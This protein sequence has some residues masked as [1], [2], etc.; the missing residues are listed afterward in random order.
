VADGFAGGWPA[1]ASLALPDG[2]EERVPVA[3]SWVAGVMTV[4][5]A[6]T[7]AGPKDA[8]GAGRAWPSPRSWDMAARLLAAG[9][10]A[11]ADELVSSALVRGCVGAGAGA[12]FATWLAE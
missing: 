2:W 5:P 11:G 9:A 12:E 6:L 4:R 8:P 3:R 10:A 1:P 7:L